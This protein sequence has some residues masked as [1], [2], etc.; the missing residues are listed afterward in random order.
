[1]TRLRKD[2][3]VKNFEENGGTYEE[4]TE[5]IEEL[6]EDYCGAYYEGKAD[7]METMVK[8]LDS[9]DC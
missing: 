1:M 4:V 2:A 6:W 3:F 9:G 8:L 7:G 5:F